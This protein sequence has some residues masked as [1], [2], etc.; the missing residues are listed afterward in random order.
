MNSKLTKPG[1]PYNLLLISSVD[2]GFKK[3]H[4]LSIDLDIRLQSVFTA[5]RA[6]LMTSAKYSAE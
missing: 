2:F 4:R 1:F 5:H 6:L 3:L